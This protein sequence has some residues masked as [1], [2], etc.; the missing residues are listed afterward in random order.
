MQINVFIIYMSIGSSDRINDHF[1]TLSYIFNIIYLLIFT[2]LKLL[3]FSYRF[4]L[5]LKQINKIIIINYV[6]FSKKVMAK[7]IN[8]LVFFE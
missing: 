5:Y 6:L 7:S 2:F 3:L 8:A 4:K 1:F